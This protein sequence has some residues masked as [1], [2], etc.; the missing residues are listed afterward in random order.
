MYINL[1]ADI[2][3]SFGAYQI[4][5][6]SRLLDVVSSVN[7]ACGF[8]AGDY[9]VMHH[10]VK[11]AADRGVRIGAHPGYPDLLGFGRRHIDM[12]ADEI[13]Q[14]MVYQIGALQAVCAV[15]HTTLYHVKPH[16]ALY[17]LATKDEQV[18]HAVAQAIKDVDE[19][20]L[21]VGL[22]NS[23]LL[24]A[25]QNVGLSVVS[26]VFADRTYTKDGL[27]TPRG[28]LNAVITDIAT[29][30]EQVRNL[31]FYD[32]VEATD[33]TVIDVKADTICF[34]GDGDQAYDYARL[35]RDRLQEEGVRIQA[36]EPNG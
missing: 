32:C 14:L 10:V 11:Q 18:A 20:L 7:I 21:L 2:G 23:S 8:H 26:E 35:I 4:G 27:L 31:V 22:A 28:D 34:H 6:D 5:D 33:G 19:R 1:N 15:H 3:E 16:G 17:N 9:R 30:Q 24:T 12:S 29:M 36:S 25:G 13:Y